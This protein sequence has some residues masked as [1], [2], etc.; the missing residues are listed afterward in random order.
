LVAVLLKMKKEITK[1]NIIEAIQ[2][3]AK[4]KGRNWLTHHEF[5]LELD[6]SQHQFSNHFARWNDA[7]VQAGLRPLSKTGRPDKPKGMTKEH[8]IQSVLHIAEELGRK[9]IS[10]TEFTKKTGIS[11][12]PIH[13]LFGSWEQFV[14]E[15][16]LSI[17]PSH[18]KKIPDEALF[19]EFYRLRDEIGHFPS[20]QELRV[21]AKYSRGTF[22]NRFGTFSQFKINAIQFGIKTGLVEPNIGEREIEQ[23]LRTPKDMAVSCEALNDRPVLGVRIDFRGLLHAPINELGVVYLFGMLGEEL[24]FIVESVQAGFPDCEAK[25]RLTNN[26]WQ[27]VRIEFEFKSANFLTHGHDLQKCDLIVCWVHDWRDCPIEVI[28]LKDYVERKKS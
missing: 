6:I 14:T 24:G 5:L 7:V 17:H 11:Y 3:L 23:R 21:N 13:R 27:R 15:A 2:N 19:K 9:A 8:L 28:S 10:E 4:K 16:G 18:N 1:K 12:R 26:R 25:R 22:E 20:Y